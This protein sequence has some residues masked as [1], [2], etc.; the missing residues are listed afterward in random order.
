MGWLDSIASTGNQLISNFYNTQNT[1]GE[2]EH[3]YQMTDYLQS[4][5]LEN[6]NR[7][8]EYNSPS[9]QMARLEQAGLNP[10]LMYGKGDVGNASP[11][12]ASKL[13]SGPTNRMSPQTSQ[14][15]YQDIQIK[16]EN[17]DLLKKENQRKWIENLTAVVELFEKGGN[18]PYPYRDYKGFEDKMLSD[19][20]E[21]Y[22]QSRDPKHLGKGLSDYNLDMSFEN[23]RKLDEQ[24]QALSKENRM[25]Q[26]V[27]D[28]YKQH[29]TL[30][31]KDSFEQREIAKFFGSGTVLGLAGLQ[32][33]VDFLMKFK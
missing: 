24:I 33:A 25:T 7:Q 5:D 28:T 18:S 32:K 17:I 23:L 13:A 15:D 26:E 9:Q 4:I 8:N 20:F 29:G 6:W 31:N 14:L 3:Q 19:F 27:W 16:K 1:S 22:S 11:V 12:P 2:R 21:Q 30:I 10:H